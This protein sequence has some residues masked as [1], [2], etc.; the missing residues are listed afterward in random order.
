MLIET[1]CLL[2]HAGIVV[3]L[4]VCVKAKLKNQNE[5][6]MKSQICLLFGAA[7][8]SVCTVATA[9]PLSEAATKALM[10][11]KDSIVLLLDH[12]TGLFQTV[13]DIPVRDLRA[14]TVVLAKVA[15]QAKAPI[16]TTASEP[17]GPNGPLMQELWK[18]PRMLLTSPAKAR[19]ARGITRILER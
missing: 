11:P 14:N 9:Q 3:R 18:S 6:I 13:K 10:D 17:S 8:S 7:L 19:S 16:I 1:V 2:S 5:R 4:Y 15:A 12:Q